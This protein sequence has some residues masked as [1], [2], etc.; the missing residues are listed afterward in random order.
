MVNSKNEFLKKRDERDKKFFLAGMNQGIQLVH[1]FLE[2]ALRDKETMGKDTFGKG[3]IDKIFDK[4]RQCDDHFHLAFTD[5]VEA[6]KRQEEL[7]AILREIYGDKL[8][9]FAERY[10]YAKIYGYDKP[11]KGWVGDA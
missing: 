6:D 4:I 8:V 1:D 7:D 11:R 3:R 10:P 5:H 9:P 2:V